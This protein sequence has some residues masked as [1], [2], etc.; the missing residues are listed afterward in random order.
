VWAFEDFD[1]QSTVH[2]EGKGAAC[3]PHMDHIAFH[4]ALQEAAQLRFS[5]RL[6]AEGTQTVHAHIGQLLAIHKMGEA[7][8]VGATFFSVC[9]P[10]I[11]ILLEEGQAD[12][13]FL[14]VTDIHAQ[15]LRAYARACS[16][17]SAARSCACCCLVAEHMDTR[18]CVCV[19]VCV[20][21][22]V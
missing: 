7:R 16:D 9:L 11:K 12:V 1:V 3:P 2:T 19:C 8:Q 17:V 5:T 4:A 18:V 6:S 15:V 14:S 10:Q 20:C 21:V 22:F 13:L